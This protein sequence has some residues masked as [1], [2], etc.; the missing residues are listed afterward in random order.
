MNGNYLTNFNFEK[1]LAGPG[2]S[3]RLNYDQLHYYILY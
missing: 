2:Q 1:A 3:E